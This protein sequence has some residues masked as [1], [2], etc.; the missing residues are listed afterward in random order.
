ML[1]NMHAVVQLCATVLG[2]IELGTVEEIIDQQSRLA[3]LEHCSV[4][5]GSFET[6]KLDFSKPL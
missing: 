1:C 4:A 5:E 2:Y 6:K 3:I